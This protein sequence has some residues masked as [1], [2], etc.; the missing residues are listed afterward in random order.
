MKI[1][2]NWL[3]EY[4][5]VKEYFKNPAA[6]EK[7]LTDAGLEG[8]GFDDAAKDFKNVVVGQVKVLGKHPNADK[9]TL[10]QIDVGDGQ[11]RQIVCG[12]KNHKQGDKV[13]VALPGAVLPGDFAIK[14]SKI[15]DVESQGMLC[16][17][18][19]LGFKKDA[20]GIVILPADAKL[21]TPIAEYYGLNDII[22]EVN[23]T[24]NRA[25]CL[26]HIGIAREVACLLGRK[27]TLPSAEIKTGGDDVKK[28]I[29]IQLNNK[30]M[31]PRY[32]GRAVYNVKV[33]PS[34]Q[35][36]K[37]RLE[38][39]GMT[40]INNIV[41]VT[42]YVMLE[43]G[44]PLH[45]FDMNEL[46]GHK[47][48]I[49]NARKEKFK[50]FMGTDLELTGEELTIRDGERAVALAGIIG[51]L[52]S[53]VTE[54]TT[55]VFVEAAHFDPMQVRRTSR[56]H[57]VET[58]S[59][60]RFSRGTDIEGVVE[61]LN[62]A[63]ALIQKVAGGVV[64][65]DHYDVYPAPKV[66]EPVA[67]RLQ[68]VNDRLGYSVSLND[69]VGWMERLHC[70]VSS[71]GAGA[72]A[73]VQVTPPAFRW[74]L[75]IEM[76]FVEE[77]AR[78]NGYDK[79]P[80][81][82]PVL[83][84]E[85]TA[86]ALEYRNDVRAADLLKEQGYSQA[87]NYGFVAD[88]WQKKLITAPHFQAMGLRLLG[89][90][91]KLVN[92]LSDEINVMRQSLI[93][94]LLT[95]FKYNYSRGN[96][97]GRVFEVGAVMGATTNKEEPFAQGQRVA[98]IGW[99]AATNMWAKP[100][101]S[102][103][104]DIKSAVEGL[105]SGLNAS[106]FLWKKVEEKDVPSFAHP[107]QIVTLF[108]QGKTIGFIASLHP[109]FKDENKIRG[110][111]AIAEFDLSLL[112][113]GQPKLPKYKKISKFQSVDRDFSFVVPQTVMAQEIVKEIQKAGA[114]LLQSVEIVD[115]FKG[116]NLKDGESSI[117]FRI[118]LQDL[119]ATLSDDKVTATTKQIVDSVGQKLGLAI[120]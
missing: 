41:D 26:S 90:A 78:L 6:L 115:V 75:E 77:Y 4:V 49:E 51:G 74:D 111:A 113:A 14:L 109:A 43:Y 99:G 38:A 8:E 27:I 7:I 59:C 91:V 60:Q 45:A 93:P 95:N 108:Y 92:P 84:Q 97:S 98:M 69:F 83:T 85:P 34:P 88:V 46:R 5:D 50:T 58:D 55:E 2:L 76:D 44:Q 16:S 32:A 118:V 104:Y 64:S 82:F 10:C 9:L 29:D 116:G 15:R 107:G 56:R 19:E 18:S 3:N 67:V 17:E 96:H 23:V 65:K 63:C 31:C 1:S 25:D 119:E 21:G 87:V 53:G 47:I 120:R 39:A 28:R 70:K 30:D 100:N 12:A 11:D 105:L 54:A 79:I 33:G 106:G 94:G 68:I 37:S 117:T 40:S 57:G 24:P 110:E 89:D 86:H 103:I 102:V 35:W 61:A 80:E 52:N 114:P 71:S 20:E 112:M 13:V 22:F 101:R 81:T 66:K 62:R 48:V 72:N 42:N 36:L 73:V